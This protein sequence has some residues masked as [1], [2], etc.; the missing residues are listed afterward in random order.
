MISLPM[1]SVTALDNPLKAEKN[2]IMA[3]IPDKI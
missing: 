1:K 3:I 2:N